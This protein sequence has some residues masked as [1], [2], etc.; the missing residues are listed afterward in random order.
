MRLAT[1]SLTWEPYSRGCRGVAVSPSFPK[2]HGPGPR[3]G[4]LLSSHRPQG[5]LSPP[6]RSPAGKHFRAVA[7]D[8]RGG[9]T[10]LKPASLMRTQGSLKVTPRFARQATPR[11]LRSG[12]G[13]FLSLRR[14]LAVRASGPP[15]LTSAAAHPPPR[16]WI[17]AVREAR[18][19]QGAR[20][21]RV[22]RCSC[23]ESPARL[24][25]LQPPGRGD[26]AG[27]VP[28]HAHRAAEAPLP[29]AHSLTG[30]AP[31]SRVGA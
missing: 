23:D 28:P 19:P 20:K 2:E 29:P 4:H 16:L 24:H 12:P 9:S 26:D 11:S 14:P 27:R 13:Q 7:P 6:R 10:S 17:A 1:P 21:V 31:R 18:W 5:A 15:R 30:I 25:R 22:G 8:Q 3:M